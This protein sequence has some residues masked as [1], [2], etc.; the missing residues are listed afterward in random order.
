[1]GRYR[2]KMTKDMTPQQAYDHIK[3]AAKAGSFPSLNLDTDKCLYRYGERA[4]LA[5][6]FLDDKDYRND[7]DDNIISGVYISNTASR[8]FKELENCPDFFFRELAQGRCLID[9]LQGWHDR[10]AGDN[11]PYDHEFFARI[12]QEFEKAGFPVYD[13]PDDAVVDFMS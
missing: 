12:R 9:V 1:M 10:F 11:K 8:I 2:A 3:A 13:T 6:I 4:C 5:G 7:M